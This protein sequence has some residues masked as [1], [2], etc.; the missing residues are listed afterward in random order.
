[1]IYLQ[2][3]P[4]VQKDFG[5]LQE[6]TLADYWESNNPSVASGCRG[7]ALLFSK[8]CVSIVSTIEIG[9][10]DFDETESEPLSGIQYGWQI[11]IDNIS[12]NSAGIPDVAGARFASNTLRSISKKI[13]NVQEADSVYLDYKLGIF[14]IEFSSNLICLTLVEKSKRG[15][16]FIMESEGRISINPAINVNRNR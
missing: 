12:Q 14:S 8:S 6:V 1:M 3:A 5:I 7:I 11:A 9:S 2:A 10:T 16:E 4:V 13:F 15:V